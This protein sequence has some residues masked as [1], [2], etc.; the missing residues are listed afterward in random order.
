MSFSS[1]FNRPAVSTMTTSTSSSLAFFTPSAATSGGFPSTP[2]SNTGTSICV[3]SV[4][5]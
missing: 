3:P 1:M 4:F 5:N 2:I